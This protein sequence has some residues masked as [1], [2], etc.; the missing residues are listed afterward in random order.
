MPAP[1]PERCELSGHDFYDHAPRATLDAA[2]RVACP[3]CG[4]PIKLGIRGAGHRAFAR[5]IPAHKRVPA[6]KPPN[7]QP[8]S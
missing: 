1:E 2:G 6:G 5:R 3:G 7:S 4:K 8:L